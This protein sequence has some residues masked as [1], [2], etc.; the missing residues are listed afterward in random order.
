M[1]K[2]YI[3]SGQIKYIIDCNDEKSAILSAMYH[4]RNK[5]VITGPKICVSERG[6]EDFKNWKCYDISDFKEKKC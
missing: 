2:Y 4:Y 3:K 1:P 5:D 6:F